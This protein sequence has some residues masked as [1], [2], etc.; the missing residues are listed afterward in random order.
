MVGTSV[1][2]GSYYGVVWPFVVLLLNY[3][4]LW[5]PLF[6]MILLF[7]VGSYYGII[8]LPR[9]RS[10]ASSA[11]G[12]DLPTQ[13]L[14]SLKLRQGLRRFGVA[15]KEFKLSYQTSKTISFTTHP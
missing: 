1:L 4:A 7:G 11:L 6:G 2:L 10:P 14:P 3:V 5:G 15:V 12:V 13:L 8:W 9:P